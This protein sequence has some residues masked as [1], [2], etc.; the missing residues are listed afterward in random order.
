VANGGTGLS[1][2]GAANN[3]LRSNGTAFTSSALAATDLPS[4]SANYIQNTTT[5]QAATNFSISGN[6]TA[7]GVL[8][9]NTVNSV[10]QYNINGSRVLSLGNAA[11]TSN[12]FVGLNAG[13]ISA[14]NG[15]ANN[16]NTFVGSSVGSSTTSGGNSFFGGF[17]GSNN[18]TGSN[19]TIIGM[20]ANVGESNLTNATALGAGAIVST[21]N[22]VVL[23]RAADTVRIPGNLDIQNGTIPESELG[24]AGMGFMGR[25]TFGGAGIQFFS[26]N[27]TSTQS[28]V[29]DNV[30]M[31]TPNRACTAQNLSVQTTGTL[32]SG[33]T[34]I[35][36][37]LVNGVSTPVSCTV[38]SS[39]ASCNSGVATIGIPAGQKVSI[40]SNKNENTTQSF[41]FGWECR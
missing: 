32:S 40:R 34:W 10:T 15:S 5:Q 36:T 29:G 4:G 31:L 6:G 21:S 3:F 2:S 14:L 11:N 27:G 20:N 30:E 22:T 12:T 28:S 8:S 39:S 19:N 13:N 18:T 35:F 33:F 23:G 25:A 41:M 7:G 16:L 38:S 26:P 24:V 17:A 37:L 1:A 9:G